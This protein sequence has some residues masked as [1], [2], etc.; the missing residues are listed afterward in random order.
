M[1]KRQHFKII[2]FY[3]SQSLL[4]MYYLNFDQYI[5]QDKNYPAVVI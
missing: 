5:T 3:F 2:I 4:G 1:W